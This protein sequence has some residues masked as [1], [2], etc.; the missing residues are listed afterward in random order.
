M[1]ES[2]ALQA[3]Q[4]AIGYRFRDE[5]LLHS[6]LTH[7][8][9]ADTRVNSNERLEFLGDAVLGMVVCEELYRQFPQYLEGELTKIKSAVVSRRTCAIISRDL[10]LPDHLFIGKG[11]N[12]RTQLPHSLAA[13]VYESLIAAIYLDSEDIETVRE[14]ILR[15]TLPHIQQAAE[16]EHQRNF[17]SQLQQHA[18]KALSATPIYDLLD[19]KGPDHSKCFEI[20][21]VIKGRRFGSAWGPSKK[22]AEQ[23]AAYL[24]LRE[25]NIIS[26]VQ[27]FEE[28][29]I[30]G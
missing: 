14:F 25:M 20:S 10:G 19:E 4:D 5:Q 30:E 22:E 17:K 8:S 6:A 21:V 24:A 12:A 2:Q 18:Q 11:M 27:E 29:A 7:A 3:V 16:S 9:I 13:A 28:E 1:S 26:L 23:K 15:T